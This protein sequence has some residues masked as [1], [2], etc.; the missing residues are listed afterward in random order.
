[1]LAHYPAT[2]GDKPVT[3]DHLDAGL[4]ELRVEMSQLRVELHREI[5]R[6][7]IGVP[8]SVAGIC[9]VIAFITRLTI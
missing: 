1:M 2:E 5:N 4:G 7:L 9:A 8:A 3:E 6:L